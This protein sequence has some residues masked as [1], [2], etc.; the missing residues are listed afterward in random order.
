MIG[1]L[2]GEENN[3]RSKIVKIV[4]PPPKPRLKAKQLLRLLKKEN[5][6]QDASKKDLTEP[7][8]NRSGNLINHTL[9]LQ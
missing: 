1:S 5:P 9:M 6:Q 4:Q 8:K 7:K 3:K 2:M